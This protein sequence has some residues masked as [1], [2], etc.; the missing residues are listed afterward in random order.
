MEISSHDEIYNE[1]YRAFLNDLSEVSNPYTG[2][3]AEYWSDGYEDARE[4]EEIRV[5]SKLP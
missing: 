2:L 5:R 1:G 4:D 3:D